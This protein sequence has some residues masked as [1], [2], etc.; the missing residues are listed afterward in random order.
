MEVQTSQNFLIY[1]NPK[2]DI[3]KQVQKLILTFENEIP[4]EKRENLDYIDLRFGDKVYY[5]YK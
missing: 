4:Q 5:K 1:F 2:E 3:E